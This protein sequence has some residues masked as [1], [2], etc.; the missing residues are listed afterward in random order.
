MQS[1]LVFLVDDQPT[2]LRALS[3]V[4]QLAGA[5]VQSFED[6]DAL[7]EAMD[8]DFPNV[9]VIDFDLGSGG[10]GDVLAR[11]LRDAHGTDCPP[12]LLLTA[13]LSDV[14][15]RQLVAFDA[16]FSKDVSPDRLVAE[17]LKRAEGQRSSQSSFRLKSGATG[18]DRETETG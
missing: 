12:L 4:L 9:I 15:D 6:P 5:K 7:V 2:W 11:R 14:K 18:P 17:I 8:R 10:T 16:A 1:P 3:R 13:Q